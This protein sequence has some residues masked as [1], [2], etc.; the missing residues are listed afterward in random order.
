MGALY[1]RP[2]VSLV[3]QVQA[4]RYCKEEALWMQVLTEQGHVPQCATDYGFAF[5]IRTSSVW[6]IPVFGAFTQL[7]SLWFNTDVNSLSR[8]VKVL[9]EESP[10]S[11]TLTP[12]W[13]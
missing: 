3:D 10:R 7:V 6:T 11:Q 1:V 12:S 5:Q 8:S 4:P 13:Q 2:L 9:C